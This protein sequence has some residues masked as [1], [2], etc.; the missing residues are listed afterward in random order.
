MDAVHVTR[1]GTQVVVRLA[2]RV[3]DAEAERL[4]TAYDEVARLALSRVVVDVEDAD[5][6][7]GAGLDFVTRLHARWQVR[8]LNADG[9]LRSRLLPTG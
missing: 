6:I 3:G 5:A 2:G 8:V 1:I 4:A 7:E 9:P